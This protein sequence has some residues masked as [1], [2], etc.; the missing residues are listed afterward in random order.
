M[1]NYQKYEEITLQ[2]LE[3]FKVIKKEYET[4]LRYKQNLIEKI[5]SLRAVDY[6]RDRVQTGNAA[7][8]S[9]QERYTMIL[10][11]INSE[12]TEYE[13]FLSRE[14]EIIKNQIARIRNH[15]N[16]KEF[17]K[18]IVLRYIEGWK[19]SEITQNLF[20]LENDFDEN[21]EKYRDKTM[22]WHREA[23]AALEKINTQPYVPI[24]KQLN[25][26]NTGGHK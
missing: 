2:R 10:Q 18:I 8:M 1:E 6:S 17:R 14:K 5:G 23:L 22:R 7:K 13:A 3:D 20:W 19:F 11:K 4:L 21:L 25:F 12:I 26:I 15:E 16:A 9:E 24:M